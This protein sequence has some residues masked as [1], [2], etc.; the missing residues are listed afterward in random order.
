MS[1]PVKLI[2]LV[3]VEFDGRSFLLFNKETKGLMVWDSY[4]SCMTALDKVR[5]YIESSHPHILMIDSESQPG[6]HDLYLN[7]LLIHLAKVESIDRIK[8]LEVPLLGLV[9]EIDREKAQAYKTFLS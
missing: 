1:Q 3:C 9:C 7:D 5:P 2:F 6:V 8:F 4:I